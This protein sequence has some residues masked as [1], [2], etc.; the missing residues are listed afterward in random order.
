VTVPERPERPDRAAAPLVDWAVAGRRLRASALVLL[1]L[2]LVAWLVAGL[3]HGAVRL[4]DVW[5]YLGLAAV[6]MFLAEVVVVGGSAVRGL[7]RAGE[8]GE[9]LAGADVG[10]LPP[11]VTRRRRPR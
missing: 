11:Q 2:A 10:L 6:G 4:A 5:G 1:S 8:R 9:R 7:L 3:L